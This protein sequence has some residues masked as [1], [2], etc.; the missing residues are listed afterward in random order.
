MHRFV[1]RVLSVLAGV[2]T[3]GLLIAAGEASAATLHVGAASFVPANSLTTT[4]YSN[5]GS[6]LAAPERSSRPWRCHRTRR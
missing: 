3:L 5:F 2:A 4:S 6:G 1:Q